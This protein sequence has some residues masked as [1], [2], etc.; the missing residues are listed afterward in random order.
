MELYVKTFLV[1]ISCVFA[2]PRRP[3]AVVG[4]R[5]VRLQP[6]L[7]AERTDPDL[8]EPDLLQAPHPEGHHEG[9]PHVL[10]R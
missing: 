5:V 3:A 10:P 4:D 6:A 9:A 1:S 7:P 8:G 2:T